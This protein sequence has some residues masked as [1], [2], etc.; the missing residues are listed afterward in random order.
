M[1][2]DEEDDSIYNTLATLALD[3]ATLSC[4]F[5]SEVEE[6]YM[7]FAINGGEAAGGADLVLTVS[8]GKVDRVVLI[9]EYEY[10][11]PAGVL[12]Y[13]VD[14]TGN[15]FRVWPAG[16]THV[17]LDLSFT[18]SDYPQS[19]QLEQVRARWR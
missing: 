13:S 9:G 3:K 5:T 15:P 10:P 6:I 19:W 2:N 8:V 12:K 1:G 11:V 7:T 18:V 4:N 17:L 16:T 14:V